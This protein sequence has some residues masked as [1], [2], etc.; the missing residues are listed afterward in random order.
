MGLLPDRTV[1]GESTVLRGAVDKG[2][3]CTDPLAPRQPSLPA[4]SEPS[5][6]VRSQDRGGGGDLV[7]SMGLSGDV[8]K[9]ARR[10]GD[11]S[12]G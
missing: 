9:P 11:R 10:S 8:E 7:G 5:R 1:V 4:T 12:D 3:A 6:R 2:E